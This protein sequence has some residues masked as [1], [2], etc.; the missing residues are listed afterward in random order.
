MDVKTRDTGSKTTRL[1]ANVTS[2][3]AYLLRVFIDTGHVQQINF[4]SGAGCTA[5]ASFFSN[6][7]HYFSIW[8]KRGN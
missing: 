2:T 1:L 8:S 3:T 6:F 7:S 5:R 4:M